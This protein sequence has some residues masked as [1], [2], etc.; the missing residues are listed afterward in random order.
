M[1]TLY[2]LFY[3]AQIR[4]RKPDRFARDLR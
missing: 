2:L 4:R 3:L 1:D